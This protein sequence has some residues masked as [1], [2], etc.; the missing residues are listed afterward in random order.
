MVVG[1]FSINAQDLIILRDGN[2]IEAIVIELSPSEIRYRRFDHL[3]GPIIVI[4][5]VNVLSIRYE[6]GRLETFDTTYTSDV[7]NDKNISSAMDPNRLTFGINIDPSGFALFGPSASMEFTKGKLNTQIDFRFPSIGLL[8]NDTGGFG[9][10]LGFNYFHHTR[11]GGFY[12]G[13]M[14]EFSYFSVGGGEWYTEH[15][16]A[17]NTGYKFVLS[18]GIYFRTGVYLG[19][20]LDFGLN[21]RYNENGPIGRFVIRPDLSIGYNF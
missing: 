2:V 20:G 4:P 16:W 1:T 5:T 11:I 3:D 10:G 6:N 17:I 19:G 18:P 13:G 7:Q 15:V 9:I 21:G 14:Y 8:N 12:L